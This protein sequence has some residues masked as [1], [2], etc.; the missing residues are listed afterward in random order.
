MVGGLPGNSFMFVKFEEGGGVP[1]VAGAAGLDVAERVE[2]LLELP[3][4]AL[5]L[6]SEVGEEAMSV[7]DVEGDLLIGRDGSGGTR[8]HLGFQQ[9][10]AIEAPG[11]VGELLDKLR[12]G[13][14]CGLVFVEEAAAMV[15]I[16]GRV[17]GGEDGGSGRQAVAQS[18]ERRTLLAGWGARTGGV[19]RI[20]AVRASA[21]LRD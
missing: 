1:E 14:S 8:Q 21:R 4:K 2:A 19:L 5:A 13:W 10:D 9:G 16:G 17:F 15:F 12:L 11:S 3:G 6:D 18:V 20:R 7:D